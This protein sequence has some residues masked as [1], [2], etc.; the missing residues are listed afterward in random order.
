M[1]QGT[2]RPVAG[3][4]GPGGGGRFRAEVAPTATTPG[5]AER[6]I[7]TGVGESEGEARAVQ[8]GTVQIGPGCGGPQVH[9][10]QPQAAATQAF[11]VGDEGRAASRFQFAGHGVAGQG[12]VR[13]VPRTGAGVD[14]VGVT[15]KA[16]VLRGGR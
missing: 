16:A 12:Q 14:F 7:A 1:I 9:D 11:V 2:L 3:S 10:A 15:Q 13:L 5:H 4:E 6:N 8:D